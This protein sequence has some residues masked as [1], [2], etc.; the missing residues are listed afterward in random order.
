MRTTSL[1]VNEHC[2]WVPL[3]SRRIRVLPGGTKKDRTDTAGASS[4]DNATFQ[5]ERRTR[6]RTSVIMAQAAGR[7]AVSGSAEGGGPDDIYGPEAERR[8]FGG[9]NSA[10][11]HVP[12]ATSEPMVFHPVVLDRNHLDMMIEARFSISNHTTSIK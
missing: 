2:R 12:V 10:G 9:I 11:M 7:A 5:E 3:N 8:R 6:T 4:S 1:C